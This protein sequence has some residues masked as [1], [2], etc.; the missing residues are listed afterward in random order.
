MRFP[1][2]ACDTFSEKVCVDCGDVPLKKFDFDGC[3]ELFLDKGPPFVRKQFL[4]FH[5]SVLEFLGFWLVQ[6]TPVLSFIMEANQRRLIL[7]RRLMAELL[8]FLL[9]PEDLFH[10]A[11]TSRAHHRFLR[12]WWNRPTDGSSLGT[13][14]R[15]LDAIRK[16]AFLRTPP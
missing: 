9:E 7:P 14:K 2:A 10:L 16:N 8:E 6:V 11:W 4:E 5:S 12:D 13:K 3:D 1:T 15:K